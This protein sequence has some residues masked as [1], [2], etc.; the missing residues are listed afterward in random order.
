VGS[1]TP[2]VASSH[3]NVPINVSHSYQGIYLFDINTDFFSDLVSVRAGSPVRIRRQQVVD[4]FVIY[5]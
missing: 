3:P 5:L 4:L 2:V 1:G